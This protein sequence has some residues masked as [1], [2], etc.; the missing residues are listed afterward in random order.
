MQLAFR[1]WGI[2][3]D[4]DVLCQQT[5]ASPCMTLSTDPR[6]PPWDDLEFSRDRNSAITRPDNA[7][8][9]CVMS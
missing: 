2:P 7:P 4:Q 1:F 9:R 5:S 3:M 6:S 8:I